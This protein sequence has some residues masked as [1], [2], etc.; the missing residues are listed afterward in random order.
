MWETGL[1]AS[2][3]CCLGVVESSPTKLMYLL[4][5]LG[6]TFVSLKILI[7]GV[8][9]MAQ[10]LTSP[11]SIHEDAGSIPGLGQ[12]CCRELWCRM[13]TWLISCIAV[14]VA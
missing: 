12:W 10:W 7:M 5:L 1:D 6:S 2:F 13:Q 9:V 4:P 3:C 8:A 14:A 11:T